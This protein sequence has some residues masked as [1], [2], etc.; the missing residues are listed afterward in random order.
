MEDSRSVAGLSLAGEFDLVIAGESLAIPHTAERLVA[1]LALADRPVSRIR[2]SGILWPDASADRAAKSLRSVLWRLRAL[3][4]DLVTS[5]NDRLRLHA[6][7][8]VDI[9]G[10]TALAHGLVQAPDRAALERV[11][12]LMANAELLPD[13][14]YE[15]VVADRERYRLIRLEALERAASA[16][17]DGGRLGEAQLAVLA[18]VQSEPLRETARRLELRLH[19]AQGNIAAA[20][21]GYREYREL[22]HAEFGVAPSP[23]LDRLLG[24]VGVTVA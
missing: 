11:P 15:W 12:L 19:L 21:R 1:F 2:L 22:L 16:L 6:A 10:L 14:D 17:M 18:V 3:G 7:V 20:I 5:H 9:D 8:T 4:V 13:W 24:S 23:D